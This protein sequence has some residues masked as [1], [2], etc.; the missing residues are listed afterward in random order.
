MDAMNTVKIMEAWQN[1]LCIVVLLIQDAHMF[2]NDTMYELAGVALLVVDV[3][4]I[5]VMVWS[6]WKR[7]AEQHAVDSEQLRAELE[8]IK[9][10]SERTKAESE[11]IRAES[12]RRIEQFKNE[13]TELKAENTELKTENTELRTQV[14]TP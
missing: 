9:T 7:G 12:E 1:L 13:N 2:E 4:M 10:E 3:M 14:K 5:A 8:R 6:A 11:R